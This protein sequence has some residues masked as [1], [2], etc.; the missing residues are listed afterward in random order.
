MCKDLRQDHAVLAYCVRHRAAS[1][2]TSVA[3]F[4]SA[5]SSVAASS[6]PYG[7]VCVTASFPCVTS[8]H[9]RVAEPLNVSALKSHLTWPYQNHPQYQTRQ[10]ASGQSCPWEAKRQR[11]PGR[12]PGHHHAAFVAFAYCAYGETLKLM[13]EIPYLVLLYSAEFLTFEQPVN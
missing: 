13:L 6:V 7:T 12:E 9:H 8:C 5:A 10:V 11:H 3:A 2:V 1:S 4:S